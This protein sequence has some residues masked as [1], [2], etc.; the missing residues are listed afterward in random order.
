MKVLAVDSSS[1]TASVALTDNEKLVSEFF[2]NAGLTHSETLAPMIESV[3]K[4]AG[5]KSQDIDL[6]AVTCGP[7][8][9]TGLR[10]GLAIVK[11]MAFTHKKPCVEVS[12][13]EALAYNFLET[14]VNKYAKRKNEDIICACMD[15]RRGGVYNALFKADFK[16]QNEKI[17]RLSEDRA[18]FVEN[19]NA[20]L[21]NTYSD[22]YFVGD[23]ASMCYND[24]R[25]NYKYD[26]MYLISEKNCHIKASNVAII[27]KKLYE[28]GTYVNACDLSLNYIRIPQAERLLKEKNLKFR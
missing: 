1:A 23:G 25:E 4:Y 3:I 9:F 22:I 26:N 13:L 12:S 6:Y 7:G 5:F 17:V 14:G 28:S 19:L 21:Q 2:I 18:I 20:E 24:I 16:P 11:A 8:S 27:G 15:A 10:I